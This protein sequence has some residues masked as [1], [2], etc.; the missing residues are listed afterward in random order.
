MSFNSVAERNRTNIADYVEYIHRVGFVM[1][2]TLW[3]ICSKT[4]TRVACELKNGNRVPLTRHNN[5][6]CSLDLLFFISYD[7][8]PFVRFEKR[9]AITTECRAFIVPEN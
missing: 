1:R 7:A 3:A 6:L 4:I 8:R 9:H 5:N 2:F